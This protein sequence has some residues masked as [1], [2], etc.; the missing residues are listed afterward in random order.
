MIHERLGSKTLGSLRGMHEADRE[1]LARMLAALGRIDLDDGTI[2]E[3]D[4][5]PI[6][7]TQIGGPVAVDA[8]VVMKGI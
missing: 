7:L 5:N 1:S 6:I 8:L 3:I 4:M 2:D